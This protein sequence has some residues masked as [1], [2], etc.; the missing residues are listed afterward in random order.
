MHGAEGRLLRGAEPARDDLNR[1]TPG[2]CRTFVVARLLS[3][4]PGRPGGHSSAV[5]QGL[6]AATG[7][8]YRHF[9]NLAH[10]S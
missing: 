8:T 9:D 10:H 2:R 3:T 6:T 7:R 5:L 1:I 4:R